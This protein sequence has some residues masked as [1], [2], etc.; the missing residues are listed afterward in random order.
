MVNLD[1]IVI[2]SETFAWTPGGKA[3]AG[4]AAIRD[5]KRI[6]FG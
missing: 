4:V 3:C 2:P 5:E 6:D 1:L